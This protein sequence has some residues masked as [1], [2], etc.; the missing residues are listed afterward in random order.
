MFCPAEKVS[1]RI[2]MVQRAGRC[3]MG[4]WAGLVLESEL[5]RGGVTALGKRGLWNLLHPC[6]VRLLSIT[7]CQAVCKAGW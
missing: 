3:W 7:A 6:N 1:A 5:V 4:G 2:K